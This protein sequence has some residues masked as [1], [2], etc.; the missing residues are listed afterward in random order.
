MRGYLQK[1]FLLDFRAIV[2][3]GD[4]MYTFEYIRK[5]LDF[6]VF[7]K[8]VVTTIVIFNSTKVSSTLSIPRSLAAKD[9][10]FKAG[11]FEM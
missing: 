5:I 3:S 7:K 10:V 4:L 6:E 8:S 11:N 1:L 9:S 2:I